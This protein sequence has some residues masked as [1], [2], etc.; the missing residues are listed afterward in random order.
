MRKPMRILLITQHFPPERGAVRRLYEFAKFFQNGG[1]EV[2][3]LTAMP[4]YPDGVVPEKYRGKFL[5][6]EKLNDLNIY[7]SY[8]MPA[9]NAEPKKRMIGFITFLFSSLINSFRIK[10]KFDL[11][12]VSSPPVTS[13]LGRAIRQPQQVAFYRIN[14][15]GD[16]FSLS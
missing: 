15:E 16:A 12:L 1:H 10:G 7:R 8:V 13:P 6:K 5:V 3:V 2:T 11:I 9:S 14:S 4:N